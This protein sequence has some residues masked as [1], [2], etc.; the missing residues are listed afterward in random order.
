MQGNLNYLDYG[1]R[2]YDPSI[3][4]WGVVDPLA[5]LDLDFSPYNYVG[6]NPIG[7][8]GLFGLERVPVGPNGG[9]YDLEKGEAGVVAQR[10]S[11]PEPYTM[12]EYASKA[13]D[14]NQKLY[15]HP[16]PYREHFQ[17]G[18]EDAIKIIGGSI[19]AIYGVS[20]G[21]TQGVSF[22]V[23][24]R[25]LSIA[26]QIV[27]SPVKN[28]YLNIG[29]FNVGAA[30]GDFTAQFATNGNRI[31]RIN[32]ISTIGQLTIGG[33][34][35]LASITSSATGSFFSFTGNDYNLNNGLYGVTVNSIFE[36]ETWTNF[37]LGA[38]GNA[39]AGAIGGQF[40]K[41]YQ[42]DVFGKSIIETGLNTYFGIGATKSSEY[43][44]KKK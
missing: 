6:N 15:G 35:I 11:D 43:L 12:L 4:R 7:F 19:A 29:K 21:T 39:G 30:L 8:V 41:A 2:M 16:S 28:T 32:W 34:N 1:A 22:L 38:I 44:T 40:A 33:T 10:I 18:G 36:R 5:A 26:R 31:E 13:Y 23:R 3:G 17:K 25:A 24:S 37:T 20:I 14:R 9:Y 42:P 27:K